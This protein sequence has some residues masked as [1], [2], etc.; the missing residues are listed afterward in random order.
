V[1]QLAQSKSLPV[2]VDA[3]GGDHG[4]KVVVEG[5]IVA[6][7]TWGIP[8]VLVGRESELLPLVGLLGA[9]NNPLITVQ[10]ASEVISMDDSPSVAIRGKLDS[11]VRVAFQLVRDG[12][13]CAAVSPGNT[14]AMM[15]AGIAVC[16]ILPGVFRPAISSLIPRPGDLKPV[17]LIDS[18][19]NVDCHAQQLVQFALMGSHYAVSALGTQRPKVAL[20][21]NGSEPS[22]GTDMIRSAA[23]M[24]SA[25]PDINFIGYVEGRD[26]PRD[27]A[28]VIVCDGFVGNVVLK[29]MEGTVE[30]VFDSLRAHVRSSLRGQIGMWLAKPLFKS[31][32]RDKLDPS[33]YGGAPLLGLAQVG[34]VC[35]GSSNARA[36]Q[37]AVRAAWRF[38]DQGLVPQIAEALTHLDVGA[39]AGVEDD[40]WNRIGQRF[41]RRKRRKSSTSATEDT[42]S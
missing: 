22:K 40:I 26:I 32:F 18:G 27:I 41:E 16:G 4:P 15:A 9:A 8:S 35:H 39:A 25:L 12:R 20:L 13:A 23:G 19:A 17:V 29:A 28:D 7:N 31:L 36:I 3:M 33:S 10:H 6:A 5:A 34:I 38:V 24:L 2:A 42:E 1:T 37:N 11:S 21:S 14:G 30:L